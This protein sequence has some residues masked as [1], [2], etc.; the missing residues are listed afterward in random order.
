MANDRV[1]NT[2]LPFTFYITE[3][4]HEDFRITAYVNGQPIWPEIARED[5]SGYSR[6]TVGWHSADSAASAFVRMCRD[7]LSGRMPR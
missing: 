2:D 4:G 5:N 1:E 3:H 6:H 7:L